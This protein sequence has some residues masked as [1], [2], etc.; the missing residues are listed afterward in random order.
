MGILHKHPVRSITPQHIAELVAFGC[1]RESIGRE[2]V[3]DDGPPAIPRRFR[4]GDEV[5]AERRER[6][7]LITRGELNTD[8]AQLRRELEELARAVVA[9]ERRSVA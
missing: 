1:P 8:L 6:D 7:R 5:A 4:S 9:M 2:D 3:P